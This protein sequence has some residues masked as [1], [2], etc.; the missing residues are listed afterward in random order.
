[1]GQPKRRK[2]KP[3]PVE[4]QVSDK[5]EISETTIYPTIEAMWQE[6][7]VVK[8]W[9]GNCS[10]VMQRALRD[11]TFTAASEMART[12]IFR[13]NADQDFRVFDEIQRE[14]DGENR[15]R[16]LEVGAILHADAALH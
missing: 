7:I 12:I 8:P 2:Q 13:I 10:A 14:I 4:F 16:D 6:E 1:M 9:F 11:A 5:A 3:K 15:N